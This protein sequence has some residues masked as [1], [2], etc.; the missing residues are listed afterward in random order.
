MHPWC[1]STT[2]AYL[3]DNVLEGMKRRARDVSSGKA[4]LISSEISYEDWEY[5]QMR[6]IDEEGALIRYVGPD[7]YKLNDK[8]RN[9]M[10]LT[11]DE[12]KWIKSLDDALDKLPAYEGIVRRSVEFYFEEDLQDY[13]D[14]H[15]VGSVVNYKQYIS[16][17]SGEVYN[18]NNA[19]VQFTIKSKSGR[20]NNLLNVNEKEVIFKRNAEFMVLDVREDNGTFKI[21]LEEII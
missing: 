8:L 6:K 12:Q 14:F 2:I 10:A 20:N 11:N 3:D 15:Q 4:E 9:D 21:A 19:Q 18:N 13:I 5:Q 7:A 16:S 1:R 17:T